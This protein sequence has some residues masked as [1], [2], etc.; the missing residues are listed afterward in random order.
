MLIKGEILQNLRSVETIVE[1][2]QVILALTSLL[3]NFEMGQELWGLI[4]CG[5]C[6]ILEVSNNVMSGTLYSNGLID[7]PEENTIQI[8]RDTF[9][10][11]YSAE[12]SL[13]DKFPNLPNEKQYFIQTI[14]GLQY[15]G[16]SFQAFAGNY[17]DPQIFSAL[18]SF[19]QHFG[20]QL[21]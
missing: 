13:V 6:K 19:A 3:V 2:R 21:S 10:K 4:V 11:I 9:Q 1:R 20:L 15:P 14:C 12:P 8:T 17:L 5:I 7:L 16:G 18:K